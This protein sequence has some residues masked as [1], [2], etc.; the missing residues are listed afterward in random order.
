MPKIDAA[1]SSGQPPSN[2]ILTADLPKDPN[3]SAK[4]TLKPVPAPPPASG[5]QEF[6]NSRDYRKAAFFRR[7]PRLLAR[8]LDWLMHS[9]LESLIEEA[10][11]WCMPCPE[12]VP[13]FGPYPGAYFA[14]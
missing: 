11:T 10:L 6:K 4:A 2:Y 5:I 9:P 13:I 8:S 3:V 14:C 1:G 12:L 7:A